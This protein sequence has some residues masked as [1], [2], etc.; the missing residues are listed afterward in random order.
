M[1]LLISVFNSS[2]NIHWLIRQHF[3]PW[4]A[5]FAA[6]VYLSQS[7]DNIYCKIQWAWF[8]YK[9]IFMNRKCLLI[10]LQ[11]SMP[12]FY[13]AILLDGCTL[14]G[15]TG[16]LF[17]RRIAKYSLD[18]L[19]NRLS[20]IPPQDYYPLMHERKRDYDAVALPKIIRER[21]TEYQFYRL[22]WFQRL[23]HVS[24]YFSIPLYR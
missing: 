18:L 6:H 23:L 17:D 1:E 10:M 19:K 4:L 13:R 3:L 24:M 7:R 21:D 22:L 8:P 20:H 11:E 15:K 12:P 14:G 9:D 5:E 2:L 16:A